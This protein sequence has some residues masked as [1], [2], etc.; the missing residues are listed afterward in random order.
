MARATYAGVLKRSGGTPPANWDETSISGLFDAAD[1]AIDGYTA[2]D[3]ISTTDVRA[4][5]IA[6]A[7]V[8]R[9]IKIGDSAQQSSGTTSL[10]GRA[11]P[12]FPELNDDLK[13]RID[14]LLVSSNTH[15]ISALNMIGSD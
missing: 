7:V 4:I 8:L 15:G 14:A 13:Q 12:D 10:E 1:N 6:E 11:Y 5:A 9:L 2:P 3:T